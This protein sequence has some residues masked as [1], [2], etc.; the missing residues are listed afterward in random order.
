MGLVD[1]HIHTTNSD[2]HDDPAA[3]VKMAAEHGVAVMAVTDHD[4][5]RGLGAAIEA[6]KRLGVIVIPGV[7]L[8]TVF[9]GRTLHLLGYN[10]ALGNAEFHSFLGE[11][12]AYRRQSM[13]MKME[14]VSKTLVAEGK[15]GIDIED[16]ISKQGSFFNREKAAEYLVAKGFMSDQEG[17]FQILAGMHTGIECP[18]A[19]EK[20]ITAI[21]RAGGVAIVAHPFARGTSLRKIDSDPKAQEALLKELVDLGIDGIECYQSEYGPEETAFALSLAEKYGLLVSA[22]SDWHGAVGDLSWGIK[23]FKS[24]YPEHIGGLG[25]T[26]EKVYPLLGRLGIAVDKV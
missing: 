8:S 1:L 13:V 22:G 10:I 24:F 7:E 3:V 12:L 6:G 2:G 20:A 9:H 15:E 4:N 26:A 18:A 17:A 25:V 23:D 11:L 19:I 5:L 14:L 16:Y 21:H